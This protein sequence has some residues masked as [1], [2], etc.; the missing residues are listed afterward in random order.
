MDIKIRPSIKQFWA[1]NILLLTLCLFLCLVTIYLYFNMGRY[2]MFP[3]L[4]LFVLFTILTYRYLVLSALNWTISQEV[5]YQ[6][7]GVAFS[8]TDHLEMYRIIDYQETQTPFQ[9]LLN[10][11]TVLLVSTDKLNS[12]IEV[13]GLPE[14]S[15]LMSIIRERVELCKLNKRIYEVTNN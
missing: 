10:I 8:V 4:C 11:K 6:R 1:E 15:R 12:L 3:S 9:K 5:I 14:N 13:K 7:R 2:T